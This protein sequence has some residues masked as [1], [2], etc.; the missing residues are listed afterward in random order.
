LYETIKLRKDVFKLVPQIG[1]PKRKLGCFGIL[2]KIFWYLLTFAILTFSLGLSFNF[3]QNKISGP[4]L[5]VTYFLVQILLLIVAVVA[6]LVISFSG[7]LLVPI[8]R[9]HGAEHK[10]INAFESGEILT[11]S[12]IKKYS[13]IHNRCGTNFSWFLILIA[14]IVFPFLPLRFGWWNLLLTIV[15]TL[16]IFSLS[17]E[18]FRL[19]DKFSDTWWAKILLTPALWLQHFTTLEPSEKQ[20]EVA[21]VALKKA[22]GRERKLN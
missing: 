5:N 17:Y 2:N 10:T 14:F 11:P 12:K 6:I 13:R 1:L 16:A 9:Y 4:F 18:I 15:Y 19:V 20:I 22:V 21:V 3:L 7:P 8:F